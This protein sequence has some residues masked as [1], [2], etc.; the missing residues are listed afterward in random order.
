M[1]TFIIKLACVTALAT[2]LTGC[3]LYVAPDHDYDTSP[4]ASAPVN[5]GETPAA[6]LPDGASF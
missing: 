2:C 3:I 6:T 4:P 5:T 1:K